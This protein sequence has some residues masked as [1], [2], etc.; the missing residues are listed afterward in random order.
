MTGTD[1]AA[2][3]PG[4]PQLYPGPPDAVVDLRSDA[5]AALVGGIWR[6]ADAFVVE[7][8]FPSIGPDLAPSGPP[9]ATYDVVPHAEGADFDDSGW[10]V[11]AP[12]EVEARRSHGKVCFCWYR[13]AVTLPERL[14][15]VATA[16]STV[17]F[18]V[19]VDDYAEVWVDGALP[20]VLGQTGGGVAIGFNAPNRVVLTRDARPGQRF[21]LAVFG[22]NGPLSA[23]PRNFI[24]LR[25][26]SLDVYAPGRTSVAWEVP[27]SVQRRDAALDAVIAPGAVLEQLAGGFHGL[28]GAVWASAGHLL[29]SD[30]RANVI[31]RWAPH[32]TVEVFRTKS[33]Y[34]GVDIGALA[35][36][37][38]DGLAFD[39]Q[40]R[41][42]ICQRGARRVL[43]VEPHGNV[44]VL[45][46]GLGVP[47]DCVYRDDGTLYV[48][49][50]TGL[51]KI[52]DRITLLADLTEPHGLALSADQRLLYVGAGDGVRCHALG[53]E[54]PGE[55]VLDLAALGARGPVRGLAMDSSGTLFACAGDGLWVVAPDT[56]VL[57][58]LGLPDEPRGLTWDDT[59]LSITTATA[60]YRLRTGASP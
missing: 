31:Y 43:R 41:L 20:V 9:A 26:A 15:G 50:S 39:P 25:D 8:D 48:T 37:G 22:I 45:A 12:P 6:Y 21:V 23:S 32:G 53:G 51:Y 3:L 58:R 17:V 55:V 2:R 29:F 27:L 1:G 7:V 28:G 13:I 30:V 33:G 54:G 11:L 5:G 46:D 14:G 56:A 38:S 4:P 60:V 44:T 47:V 52:D 59:A 35:E 57:G 18:E 49:A 36:P 34:A 10:T 16:G 40:G 19:V 24:W 42:T